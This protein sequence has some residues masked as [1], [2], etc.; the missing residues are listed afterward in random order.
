MDSISISTKDVQRIAAARLKAFW[1]SIHSESAENIAALEEAMVS[2]YVMGAL[3]NVLVEKSGFHRDDLF[4]VIQDSVDAGWFF[5]QPEWAATQPKDG[6]IILVCEHLETLSRDMSGTHW[7][8][9][10]ER[11]P[12]VDIFTPDTRE[13]VGHSRMLAICEDCE[14]HARSDRP[15]RDAA[16]FGSYVHRHVLWEGDY[17]VVKALRPRLKVPRRLRRP[18]DKFKKRKRKK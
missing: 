11:L 13:L 1:D 17:P 8:Q 4:S 2:A 7:Y 16:S 18:G 12:S 10:P 3:Y 5:Q 15:I 6:D 9:L 14:K